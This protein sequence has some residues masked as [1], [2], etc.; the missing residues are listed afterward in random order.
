M[1]R[2][3]SIC[4]LLLSAAAMLVAAPAA[5][6]AKKKSQ[7]NLP[8]ITRVQPMRVSVG[9]T[10]TITGKRFKSKRSA[11]TVIFR[12][13]SGR[14]AFAKPRRASTTKL[15]VVVPAAVA[16]PADRQEQQAAAHAPQAARPGGQVLQVH[17]APAVAGRDRR[18]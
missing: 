8:E 14:S 9:G 7:A 6:A 10:L 3:I 17:D 4:L 15:R 5:F 12:S 1:R 13:A 16:R 11:N 18:R 2:L